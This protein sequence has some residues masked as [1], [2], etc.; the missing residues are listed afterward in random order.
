[1]SAI[2]EKHAGFP[3]LFNKILRAFLVEL[4]KIC[5]KFAA[6]TSSAAASGIGH[7]L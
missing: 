6:K 4:L 1:M 5:A 2:F 3:M 7:F